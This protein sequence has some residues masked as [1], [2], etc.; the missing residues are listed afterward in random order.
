MS[1]KLEI[2]YLG[3]NT[4][5]PYDKNARIND[6]AVDKVADSIEEFGFKNPIIIDRN[7]VIIAGHTRLLAAKELGYKEVPCIYADD[8]SPEQVKAFRIADNKLGEL[9]DWDFDL[10]N[11]EI[12]ELADAGYNV[13]VL[14]FTEAELEAIINEAIETPSDYYDLREGSG[15]SSRDNNDGFID[16]EPLSRN[17]KYADGKLGALAEKFIA[18]PFLVFDTKQGYWQ[19][20]KRQWKARINDNAE[21]RAD[22]TV[23]ENNMD[24]S[25]NSVSILDPVLSEIVVKNFMPKEENGTNCFDVFAGDTVFGYVSAYLGKK[26]TGI[27]LRQEQADFNNDRVQEDGLPAY[28]HCD[29]GRNVKK[30]IKEQSQ[31]LLFSCPPYFDLEVYSDDPNDASNQETFDEF[32]A[33][34]DEAFTN[35]IDCLKDNRF[36][37]IV[38]GDVRNKKNGAYYDFIGRV[39]DTFMRNGMHLYNE[40]ILLD[41]IGTAPIRA[42]NQMKSRKLVKVHQNILVFYKGDTSKINSIYGD[43]EFMEDSEDDYG[44]EDV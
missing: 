24:S 38:V 16:D 27:E 18:P 17:E 11:P 22:A 25:F 21:A 33:I 29:D 31:D 44:S 42:N 30:H 26:F 37:V 43:I 2:K 28:Y 41:A 34:L 1:K 19:D 15:N 14:G 5:K 13:D 3:I 39:K 4:V 7:N 12:Q 8:L 32:Y 20:R 40:A 35:A 6:K 10:L 9:A 36:A 23:N